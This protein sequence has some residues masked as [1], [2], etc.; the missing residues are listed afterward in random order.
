MRIVRATKEEFELDN[1][2]IYPIDP[3]LDREMTV[4]EF[5]KHYDFAAQV[6]KGC[7]DVGS[8]NSDAP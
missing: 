3:P 4:E 7:E 1:G 6:V 8:D 2:S 5:Q